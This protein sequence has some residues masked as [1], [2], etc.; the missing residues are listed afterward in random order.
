VDQAVTIDGELLIRPAARSTTLG[1][2]LNLLGR[3]GR[4]VPRILRPQRPGLVADRILRSRAASGRP[5]VADAQLKFGCRRA[6]PRP[7]RPVT[8]QTTPALLRPDDRHPA[9]QAVTLPKKPRKSICILDEFFVGKIS[10]GQHR[11]WLAGHA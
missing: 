1:Q 10:D 5:V 11:R 2:A 3:R 7:E 6:L 9:D 4:P 8:M